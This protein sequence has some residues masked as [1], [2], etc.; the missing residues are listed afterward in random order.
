LPALIFV[1]RFFH[2]DHSATS[3]MLSDLAFALAK[4]GRSVHVVTSRLRYDAPEARLPARETIGGVEI[5]RVPTTG[6]GRSRLILRALDY[7]TFCLCAARALRALARQG[8][9]VI[10]KTDPPMLS[11]VVAPIARLR[12][13]DQVNWL[14]DVFPEVATALG[15]GRSRLSGA[16]FRG[17]RQVRDRSLRRARANVV[18]GRHMAEHVGRLGVA[19]NRIRLIPN[20]ADGTLLRPLAHDRNPLRTLWGLGDA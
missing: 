4:E 20:W 6:F 14:Q 13:A 8:D 12:D 1:N 17:L 16:I 11:M 19:D 3:Q 15:A 5:H 10:A 2:P 18:L 7:A 9:I